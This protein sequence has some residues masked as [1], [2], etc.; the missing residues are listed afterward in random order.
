MHFG[1]AKTDFGSQSISNY[2]L[3]SDLIANGTVDTAAVTW[4]PSDTLLTK[5][6]ATE[7]LHH[8]VYTTVSGCF[9]KKKHEFHMFCADCMV[10]VVFGAQSS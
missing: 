9:G 10:F 7:G 3:M 8:Y 4:L 2:G 5:Y 6:A 1:K